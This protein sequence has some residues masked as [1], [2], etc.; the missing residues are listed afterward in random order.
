MPVQQPYCKARRVNRTTQSML[1]M[2]AAACLLGAP[3]VWAV[4]LSTDRSQETT[5]TGQPDSSKKIV[6][7]KVLKMRSNFYLLRGRDGKEVRVFVTPD[8]RIEDAFEVGDHIQ[9]EI[10]KNNRADV[11]RRVPK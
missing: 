5:A 9:A 2:V 1:R 10:F 4:P 8:T 11:I 6:E 7:G 3:G